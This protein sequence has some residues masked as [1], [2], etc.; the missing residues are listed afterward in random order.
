LTLT[1]LASVALLAALRSDFEYAWYSLPPTDIGDLATFESARKHA[2]TWARAEGSLSATN[3]IRYGRP[4]ESDTYR[5][6]PVENNPDLWVQVRVPSGLEGPHFVPPT[7]F[8]GRL[9]PLRDAGLRYSGLPSAAEEATSAAP[10][11]SAWILID[12]EAPSTTRWVMGLM[13]LFVFCAGFGIYGLA[14]LIR[15]VKT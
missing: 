2:N 6:A 3:A 1:V 12:G 15:P 7:S 11:P 14:R 13:V 4:L 8:V 10:T 9:V 5:L